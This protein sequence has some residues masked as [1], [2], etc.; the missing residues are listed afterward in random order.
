MKQVILAIALIALPVGI[1]AGGYR[2]MAQAAAS[3]AP[4]LGDL[5]ALSA[6]VTDTQATAGTGNLAAAERRITDFETAWDDDAAKL[7]P[8]DPGQWGAID[9]AADAAIGALGAGSPEAGKVT[10]TLVALGAVLADPAGRGA[11]AASGPLT[12][13]GAAVS[14][15]NGRPLP[16][17]DML[18]ALRS[19]LGAA[20]MSEADL[21]SAKDFQA[22]A[23]ERCNADDDRHADEFSAQGLALASN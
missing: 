10:T 19:A 22:K 11:T 4:G 21:A 8:L 13:S 23:T 16:C 9:D 20:K 15:A 6:I 7:R 1:F 3:P 12:V 17:E 18:N 2:H 5:S 14:D